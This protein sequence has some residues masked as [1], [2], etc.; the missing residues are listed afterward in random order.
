MLYKSKRNKFI[1]V[2]SVDASRLEEILTD[3][4][5]GSGDWQNAKPFEFSQKTEL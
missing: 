4:L 3:T 2:G 1:P 5:G